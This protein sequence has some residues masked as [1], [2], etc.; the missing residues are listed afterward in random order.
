MGVVV[1]ATLVSS[2]G[3]CGWNGF[4][5]N[6]RFVS[7]V[8]VGDDPSVVVGV[9]DVVSGVLV[10]VSE[11]VGVGSSVVVWLCCTFRTGCFTVSG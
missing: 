8:V 5:N 11:T 9:D 1:G 2:V 4:G 10:G 3:V 6:G 7:D